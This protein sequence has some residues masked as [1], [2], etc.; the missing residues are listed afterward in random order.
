MINKLIIIFIPIFI[1]NL[2]SSCSS[3]TKQSFDYNPTIAF[4]YHAI[5]EEDMDFLSNFDI[6]VTG[7]FLK[8]DKINFLKSK[9]IKLVFYDWL[10]ATYYCSKPDDW[11]MLVYQNRYQWTLDPDSSSPDP[12]GTKYGC[13]DYFYD[14]ANEDFI[15]LRI[16][17]IINYL[18]KYNYDGVFFDWGSGWNAFLENK[19]DFLINEFK[20]RHPNIDY[21]DMVLKFL[22]RL[23]ENNI[24]VMLNRGFNSEKA[25]LN[26]YADIDTA[27][28]VFTGIEC[29]SKIYNI[30]VESEGLI[31]TQDTCFK[32]IKESI[33]LSQNLSNK[34]KETNPKIKFLF[35]NYARPFYYDTGNWI[36]INNKDFAI[37]NK[38]VDRQAIFYSL[39]CSLMS[40][41]IGFTNGPDVSLD[42]VK[43][44]IYF[45]KLGTPVSN[46]IQID[47]NTYLRKFSNGLIII[48][49]DNTIIDIQVPTKVKG[50]HDFLKDE[51][52]KANNGKAPITLKS[53]IYPSGK[54]YPVGKILFYEY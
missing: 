48:G 32:S 1:L 43:D 8:D 34:A 30:Y 13:K 39:A 27:E 42:Y 23:K 20:K 24:F 52:I 15:N 45:K 16:E 37:Y 6:I 28:S 46:I 31:S 54:T 26:L 49:N 29:E 3:N 44:N 40:N 35:L 12:M 11:Q 47:E 51:F 2:L 9:N 53:Q 19:Y 41:S 22:K 50:L 10:P 17:H 38:T 7:D 18:K 14:M 33:E 25:K 5:K 21:N 36:K 4:I